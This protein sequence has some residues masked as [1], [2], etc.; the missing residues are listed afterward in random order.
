[1]ADVSFSTAVMMASRRGSVLLTTLRTTSSWF[2]MALRMVE[3]SLKA[4]L[5]AG[6]ERAKKRLSGKTIKPDHDAVFLAR[7]E[8]VVSSSL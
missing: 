8:P 6:S 1:M 7:P 2:S 4:G 5:T 3:I